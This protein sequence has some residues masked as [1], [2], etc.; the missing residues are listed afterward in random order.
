MMRAAAGVLAASLLL[1]VPAAAQATGYYAATPAA[2]PAK[3][4]LIIRST[5]WHCDT[6]QCVAAK[7][8]ARDTIVCQSV[9]QQLG[10]LSAFV[11]EGK[12][13]DDAALSACN[14]KAR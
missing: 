12:A 14:S 5:V 11:V 2:A 9:A 4:S 1:A 6:G 3:D 10:K 13:F 8:D 7:A